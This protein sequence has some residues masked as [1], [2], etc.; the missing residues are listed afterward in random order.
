MNM[1]ILCSP[2]LPVFLHGLLHHLQSGNSVSSQLPW[3]CILVHTHS[4]MSWFANIFAGE[5]TETWC[6]NKL[7]TPRLKN[8]PNTQAICDVMVSTSNLSS[9]STHTI[10]KLY[11]TL[12]HLYCIA[13]LNW[14]NL[15][16]IPK[17]ITNTSREIYF[18]WLFF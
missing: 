13:Y 12:H 3:W 8:K 10:S 7:W 5:H 4:A 1:W 9:N 14:T 16:L 17:P 18:L 11:P 2:G 6:I 15:S